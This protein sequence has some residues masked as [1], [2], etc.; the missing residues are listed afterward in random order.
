MCWNEFSMLFDHGSGR[1]SGL[2]VIDLVV[3]GEDAAATNAQFSVRLAEYTTSEQSAFYNTSTGVELGT[4]PVTRVI[5][6]GGG[7]RDNAE[8]DP[9]STTIDA[10]NRLAVVPGYTGVAGGANTAAGTASFLYGGVAEDTGD[11]YIVLNRHFSA[12]WQ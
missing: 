8:A 9:T 12:R 3:G 1:I 11:A 7:G 5:W 2:K 6:A 10:G 4:T